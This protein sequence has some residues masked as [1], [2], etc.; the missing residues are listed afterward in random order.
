M[1]LS[2]GLLCLLGFG[3]EGLI[4]GESVE[5]VGG[6][7]IGSPG[8]P[9]TF[10]LPA[11]RSSITRRLSNREIHNAVEELTGLSLEQRFVRDPQ[12]AIYDRVGSSQTVSMMHV[13]SYAEMADEIAEFLDPSRLAT[14]VPTCEDT[15][16]E[17]G[18]AARASRRGCVVSFVETI[19][20]RAYRRAL[21][22]DEQTR[23]LA[24]YDA[25]ASYEEGLRLVL[26]SIFRS[27][28]FLYLIEVG[29]EGVESEDGSRRLTSDEVAARLSFSICE[30]VPDEA[31]RSA[32]LAGELTT[33]ENVAVH[34]ERLLSA[35]CGRATLQH[36]FEQWLSIQ[37]VPGIERSAELFPDFE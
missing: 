11:P 2:I 35:P 4:G 8:E 34:A 31:L 13:E 6:P 21:V 27:P 22:A 28:N 24:L 20:A 15:P 5:V 26:H 32:A 12:D 25:S 17:D 23:I 9:N 3:C 37:D 30:T 36:F 29:E 16:F 14:L 18:D 33:P 1:R 10:E 19:G 7:E